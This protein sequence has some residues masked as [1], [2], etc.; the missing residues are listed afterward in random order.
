MTIEAHET[1]PNFR[2]IPYGMVG[3]GEG[4][5]IGAV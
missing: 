4:A 5:F 3:G 1:S 2:R